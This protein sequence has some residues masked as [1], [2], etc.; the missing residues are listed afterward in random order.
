MT[1]CLGYTI[2]WV[3]SYPYSIFPHPQYLGCTLFGWAVMSLYASNP[4]WYQLPI[5]AT[6]AYSV[7][8]VVEK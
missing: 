7:S 1:M 3:S 4:Y 2:P 5:A 6:I 8:M